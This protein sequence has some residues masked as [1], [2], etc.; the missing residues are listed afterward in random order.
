MALAL[1]TG[2]AQVT[3]GAAL[4]PLFRPTSYFCSRDVPGE[5]IFTNKSATLNQPNTIR[6]AVQTI[7]D[8]F[9]GTEVPVGASQVRSG[10]SM[11]AQVNE[12]WKVDDA[13][14]ALASIYYPASA[15]IVIR[16][17]NEELVTST[18]VADLVRRLLGAV[19]LDADD[20]LAA[21]WDFPLHQ[22]TR[23]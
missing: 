10:L 4:T 23:F 13:A 6:F 7:A 8:M 15:H 9:K 18:V 12:V 19:L 2:T 17:P 20:T 16:V 14:D 5:A 1:S 21:G 3:T 11:L 22:I